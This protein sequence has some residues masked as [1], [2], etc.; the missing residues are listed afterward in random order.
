M[1]KNNCSKAAAAGLIMAAL[2]TACS[3][4]ATNNGTNIGT[5]GTTAAESTA[6]AEAGSSESQAGSREANSEN[7][8]A[9]TSE[10]VSGAGAESTGESMPV[11]GSSET[12]SG[13]SAATGSSASKETHVVEASVTEH[14]KYESA[15]LSV[16][17]QEL[18][19]AGINFGDSCNVT[20]GNGYTL[21]DI[22]YYSGYYVR[23]GEPVMVSYSGNDYVLITY[24]NV[25]IWKQAGLKEGDTVRVELN[26]PGR[27]AATYEALKQ[28]Y[29]N[30]REDFASDTVFANFRALKGGRLK[31]N[32]LFR[33]VS[34][35]D[36]GRG[37]AAYADALVKA[38]NISCV[39]DLADSDKDMQRYHSGNEFTSDY[40]WKLYEE[41]RDITLSMSSSYFSDT[42]KEKLGQGFKHLLK[43]GGPAYIQCLEGKD[44]TG[45]VSAVLEALAG[46]D[47]DE[48]CAD[49]MQTYDNYYNISKA[50]TPDRYQ[51]I[52]SLYFDEFMSYLSGIDADD[53]E[54]L[55]AFDYHDAAENY[56]MECGLTKEETA[57]LED[58]ITK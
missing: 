22:P 12:A 52:V 33:G 40:T 37:R 9:S 49:Y 24:N 8:A 51:A 1:K 21:T 7:T 32:F 3:N 46:A 55:K 10:S 34:P 19:E 47:Y 45:F 25:G 14:P 31:D 17:R 16:D 35:V 54:A 44:R 56:I 28:K 23:S 2:L 38:N 11:S 30:N 29:S 18:A 53:E 42:Y 20:F 36:N 50:E 57:Q 27:Y 15:V 48:M 41:G 6:A 39:I 4:N 26:T 13:T 58:L 5:E 43:Y